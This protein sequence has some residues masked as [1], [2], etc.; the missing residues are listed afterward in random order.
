MTARLLITEP[1]VD[2]VIHDLQASYTVDVG[3]RGQF[4]TEQPLIEAVGQYD[5][6]L[7]MLSNPITNKV[8]N[9]GRQLKVIA[10]HAVGYN[11]IDL[12]AAQQANI[13]V[14]NTPGVVSQSTAD[15]TM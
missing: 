13:P 3:K 11:N 2:S 1:I 5:A 9:A 14:A 7:T 4:N 15:L 6:L 10:N 8:I 12:E